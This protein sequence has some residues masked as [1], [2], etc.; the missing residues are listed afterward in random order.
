MAG[1]RIRDAADARA[2]LTAVKAARGVSRGEWAREQGIDGRSL[3]AWR[4]NLGR[5]GT[6]AANQR[7]VRLVELV[8]TRAAQPSVRYAVRCGKFVVEIDERFD[9]SALR[10]LL[11]VVAAC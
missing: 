9:E 3:N 11:Q 8:P 10:R 6:P 7:R 2:C 4:I 1:R 5:R